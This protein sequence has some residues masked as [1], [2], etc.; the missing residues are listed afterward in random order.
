MQSIVLNIVQPVH[1]NKNNTLILARKRNKTT[2][3]MN[4]KFQSK[5]SSQHNHHHQHHNNHNNN[6]FIKT[7][8]TTTSIKNNIKRNTF[9]TRMLPGMGGPGGMPNMPGMDPEKMKE[10]QAAYQ[11]AMKNPET[12]KKLQ[13][14]MKQMQGMMSNPMVQQ[15]MQ[16]MQN[17]VQNEDMQKRIA[18]LKDDPEFADFFDDLRKNGPGA[19]MKYSTNQQFLKKLNDKLGG[20]E[21]IRAAAGGAIPENAAPP[22]GS[23][24]PPPQQQVAA[25]EPMP[26]VETLHDAARYGDVEAIED[27]LAIGKD[28]NARDSSQR[29]PIHYAIAFGKGSAG[30]EIFDLLV[31]ADSVDLNAKDEKQNTPLHYACG[32]GKVFAVK[33]LLEMN[34]DIKAKNGTGKTPLDLVKLEAKNPINDDA[35]LMKL[36]GA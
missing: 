17:M 2:K 8:T 27:F 32:Y 25:A 3:V 18:K 9:I 16:A 6:T 21:A 20:E 13:E 34:S 10:M 30:E 15:Q 35:E 11:E 33:K 14:Q 5:A 22:G 19:M 1:A 24:A 28:V 31:E 4:T 7:T 26:E 36:L 23:V 12:A 29:T